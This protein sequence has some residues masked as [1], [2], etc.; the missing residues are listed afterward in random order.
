MTRH[1]TRSPRRPRCGGGAHHFLFPA[2]KGGGM[3]AAPMHTEATP[4]RTGH[5]RRQP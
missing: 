5:A 2:P 1:M 4:R 3:T